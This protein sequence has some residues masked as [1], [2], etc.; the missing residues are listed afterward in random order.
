MSTTFPGVIARNSDQHK[1]KPTV[2]DIVRPIGVVSYIAIISGSLV[3]MHASGLVWGL[4]TAV[5]L[6]S[7]ASLAPLRHLSESVRLTGFLVWAVLAAGLFSI[8][9]GTYT[10][11]FVFLAAAGAGQL[12]KSS[13]DAGIVA[14]TA[15]VTN[16][17]GIIV[18]HG[19][20]FRGWPWWL[21]LGAGGG[22]YIGLA[23]RLSVE[24]RNDTVALRLET[25]RADDA[26]GAE[27]AVLERNAVACDINDAL[28]ES[29]SS[30]SI[31]LDLVDALQPATITDAAGSRSETALRHARALTRTGIA[32]SRRAV[33]ALKTQPRPVAISIESLA[34]AH[35]APFTLVGSPAELP[36]T[37]TQT[38]LRAV[39]E[40]L[41]DAHLFAPGASVRI[42]LDLTEPTWVDLRIVIGPVISHGAGRTEAMVDSRTGSTIG[43]QGVK[44]RAHLLG[45]SVDFGPTLDDVANPGWTVHVRLPR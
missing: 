16:A 17:V 39:A 2:T 4:F 42:A 30:A 37:I 31:Q 43:L 13:R 18:I 1:A 11:G 45:G 29:L 7:L 6:L 40:G 21:G 26:E 8:N 24:K 44:E 33:D 27:A 34:R 14:L 5:A 9:G 3:S 23:R 35:G 32:E 36:V 38:L 15:A 12:L 41:T 22:I 28:S 25:K 19:G 10:E 20:E